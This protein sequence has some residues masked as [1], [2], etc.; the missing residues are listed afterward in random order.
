[1]LVP[2]LINLRCATYCE[3]YTLNLRSLCHGMVQYKKSAKF[4]HN[5]LKN[6]L[7]Q[8][9][10]MQH[11]TLLKMKDKQQKRTSIRWLKNQ[12]RF[13]YHY[14]KKKTAAAQ[15]IP[16]TACHTSNYL[17]MYALSGDVELKEGVICLKSTCPHVMEP[18]SS[19]RTFMVHLIAVAVLIQCIATPYIVFFNGDMSNE[20]AGLFYMLDLIYLIGLWMDLSTAIKC[21]EVLI[22]DPKE[23]VAYK[24]KQV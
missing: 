12:W 9:K 4:L 14:S 7:R 1:M 23:I 16:V 2:S 19:F 22:T 5:K 8:A 18:Y 3:I 15:E 24:T 17:N 21:K 10:L 11:P 6:R 13:I 20:S